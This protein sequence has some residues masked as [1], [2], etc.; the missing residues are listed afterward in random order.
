MIFAWLDLV[1]V[2]A[3]AVMATWAIWVGFTH[4]R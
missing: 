1:V 3:C 4:G 2:A